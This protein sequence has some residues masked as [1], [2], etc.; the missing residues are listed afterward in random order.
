M[1]KWALGVLALTA[2][3]FAA[4]L[5]LPQNSP[6]RRPAVA[7][8]VAAA[9]APDREPAAGGPAVVDV[10]D[11]AAEL[12]RPRAEPLFVPFDAPPRADSDRR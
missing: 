6:A 11:V 4:A 5:T 7:V 3:G 9:Q 2:A 12:D 8:P 1:T 10:V